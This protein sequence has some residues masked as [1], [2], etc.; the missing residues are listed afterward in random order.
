M[1]KVLGAVVLGVI[2]GLLL[3]KKRRGDDKVEVVL[4]V[5]EDLANRI[6]DYRRVLGEDGLSAVVSGL[7]WQ[8]V[9]E[10]KA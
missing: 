3:T 2:A 4:D 7:I 9:Y 1:N 5:D 8:R 6:E 10:E